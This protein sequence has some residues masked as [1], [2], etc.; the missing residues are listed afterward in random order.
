M[1]YFIKEMQAFIIHLS[2]PP[3]TPSELQREKR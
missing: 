2:E 3:V 1:Y